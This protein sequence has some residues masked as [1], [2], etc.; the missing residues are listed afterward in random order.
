MNLK[1]HN[2]RSSIEFEKTWHSNQE[3]IK[4]TEGLNR[5]TRCEIY[6]PRKSREIARVAWDF[7]STE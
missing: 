4:N 6:L 3:K 1:K 5:V 7:T 2:N